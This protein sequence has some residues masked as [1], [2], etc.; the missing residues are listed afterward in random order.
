MIDPTPWAHRPHPGRPTVALPLT[1]EQRAQ[2]EALLRCSSTPLGE[3]RRAQ[4]LLLFADGVPVVDV[5]QL[6]GVAQGSA[7]R[8]HKRFQVADPVA[9]IKDVPK[10]GRPRSLFRPKS[11]HV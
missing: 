6:M 9:A 4:A 1:A 2:V 10:P 3:A 5:A 11:A 7:F 8:W